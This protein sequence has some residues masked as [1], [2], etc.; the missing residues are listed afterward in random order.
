VQFGDAGIA[1]YASQMKMIELLALPLLALAT[2]AFA[3][4][5]VGIGLTIPGD[6]EIKSV[7]Y[8]CE[9]HDPILVQYINAAPNFLALV[10][11]EGKIMI[12]ANTVSG[13]GAK[14]EAGQYIWWNKGT[15]AT[16][17]DVTEGLDAAPVLMCSEENNTP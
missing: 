12:F 7:A 10:P 6:A 17:S 11:I 2:P 8:D 14:Y 1:R 13:S 4:V 16:L 15:D 9:H 5:S 3:D